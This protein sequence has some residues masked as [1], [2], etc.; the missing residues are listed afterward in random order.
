MPAVR[1]RQ[2]R[3]IRTGFDRQLLTCRGDLLPYGPDLL[4][5]LLTHRSDLFGA[6]LPCRT[7]A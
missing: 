2:S 4:S 1:T 6:S 5:D 7:G 3:L